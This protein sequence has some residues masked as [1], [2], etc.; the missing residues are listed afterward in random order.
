MRKLI[1]ALLLVFAGTACAFAAGCANKNTVNI[2]FEVNG[3]VAIADVKKQSGE[4]YTLPV[5]E[6]NGYEFEGWYLTVDF[7]GE[8]VET[9]SASDSKY[10][11]KWA[12]LYTITLDLDGGSLS[13]SV[14]YLKAGANVYDFMVDY[15]PT[16]SGLTFGAWFDGESELAKNTRM[17]ENGLTLRAKYKVDYTVEV[18]KQNIDG[19]DYVKDAGIIVGADYVGAEISPEQNITGF[20]QTVHAQAITSKTLSVTA[21]ENIFKFY[22]DR[23]EYTVSFVSNYPNGSNVTRSVKVKYGKEVELPIDFTFEGYCLTGYSA[24]QSGSVEYSVDYINAVLYNKDAE[25]NTENIKYLPDRN[26][27]LYAVWSKGYTDMFGGNDY[28]FL[29]DEQTE[30]IYLARGTVYFKGI[31][32]PLTKEFTIETKSDAIKGRLNANGTFVYSTPAKTNKKYYQYNGS[33]VNQDVSV[34]LSSYNDLYYTVKKGGQD[35]TSSGQYEIEDGLFHVHYTSGELAGTEAMMM[36]GTLKNGTDVFLLR[37]EDD[38]AMGVISRIGIASNGSVGLY[39]GVLGITL[40]GFGIATIDMGEQSVN[41]NYTF[42]DDRTEITLSTGLGTELYVRLMEL[43]GYKGYMIYNE[44]TEF[45]IEQESGSLTTDGICRATYVKGNRVISGYYLSWGSYPMGG[46][47]LKILA[48][49]ET[50]SVLVDSV[51]DSVTND[52]GSLTKVT[53]YSFTEKLPTYTEYYYYDNSSKNVY[54]HVITIDDTEV[55]KASVYQRVS[56]TEYAKVAVGSYEYNKEN[57]LYSFTKEEYFDVEGASKV[58]VD[59]S[60]VKSFVFCTGEYIKTDTTYNI[61]TTYDII[62]W[63]TFTTEEGTKDDTVVYVGADGAKLTLVAEF[64]VLKTSDTIL[65]G[66]YELDKDLIRISASSVQYVRINEEEKTFTLLESAPVTAYELNPDGNYSLKNYIYFDGTANGAVYTYV[67]GGETKTFF[68]TFEKTDKTTDFNYFIFKFTSGEFTFEFIRTAS[69]SRSLFAKYNADYNGE[70]VSET[71][72]VLSLDGYNWMATFI[73]TNGYSYE[74][75]YSVFADEVIRL[76]LSGTYSLYFDLQGDRSFTVRG[77]EYGN[78]LVL[79]NG[80]SDGLFFELDGYGSAKVYTPKTENYETVCDYIDEDATYSVVGSLYTVKYTDS[81][82]QKSVVGKLMIY[83]TGTGNFTAFVI[84]HDEVVQTYVNEKDYSTLILDNSGGAIKYDARGVREDGSYTLITDTLLSY[85]NNS[86]T[87]AKM[88]VYDTVNAT[89]TPV[90]LEP[91]ACTYYSSSLEALTFSRFGIATFNGSVRVYYYVDKE[92]KITV[93]RLPEE[94]EAANIYGFVEE[95]FGKFNSEI[96]YKG[97]TYYKNNGYDLSFARGEEGEGIKNYPVPFEKTVDGKK[98][99]CSLPLKAIVFTPPGTYEFSVGG[100]VIIE[101]GDPKTNDEYSCTVVRKV[102]DGVS[103]TYITISLGVAYFRFDVELKYGGEKDGQSN[104]SYTI[105]AMYR[106]IDF[107]AY[108][109]LYTVYIAAMYDYI[110]GTNMAASLENTLGTISIKYD[111][112]KEGKIIDA[113]YDSVTGKLAYV[114]DEDGNDTNKY[115]NDGGYLTAEFGEKSGLYDACGNLI[116]LSHVNFAVDEGLYTV[117]FTGVDGYNYVLRFFTQAFGDSSYGYILYG[118]TRVQKLEYEEY[119]VEV[120][121][122]I[123]SDYSN[124]YRG[125]IMSVKLTHSEDEIKMTYG[126]LKADGSVVFINRMFGENDDKD[127][128]LSSNY[129]TITFK[130][131]INEVVGEEDGKIVPVYESVTVTSEEVST[132]YSDDGESYIDMVNSEIRLVYT[133]GRSYLVTECECDELTGKYTVTTYASSY[134]I[135]IK[136]NKAVITEVEEDESSK[137]V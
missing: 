4:E 122:I 19:T 27:T 59:M 7:S 41:Y 14:L 63:L 80:S 55:G 13:Q 32:I 108:N 114:K 137:N 134:T 115:V 53:T 56:Q 113:V 28:I 131:K 86:G 2:S 118:L 81:G 42:N 79:D 71:D 94:N 35:V 37:D 135:E 91:Y 106:I 92:G 21:S 25:S 1:A 107:P 96:E 88:Y 50:Y 83:T 17:T 116:S 125:G 126:I 84:I 39:N 61:T 66:K 119:T 69:S 111:Y 132:V 74:G 133:G 34:K 97:N 77:T 109:Y 36:L 12:Q 44:S 102:K 68:G 48:D 136:D 78:Y 127:K 100:T 117:N 129:Y 45:E 76:Q 58:P 15:V 99:E 110:F 112:N 73:S 20:K 11:A 52:D 130:E 16:K 62:F 103:E 93:Y 30:E 23:E 120:E 22:Y 10:Y 38:I 46:T 123:G 82:V 87:D 124:L 64:A 95:D 3:G 51:T 85:V 26:T 47:M 57:G 128:I 18:Y 75:Y 104:C 31:Y 121:R 40:N 43:E 5:P 24:T 72:G 89:A 67:D 70:Y 60:A 101:D 6:R 9:I 49:G 65:S 54:A 90:A 8:P 33:A 105:T 29:L 98:F